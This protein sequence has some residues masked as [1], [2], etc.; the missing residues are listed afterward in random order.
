[1][2]WCYI[3]RI[4]IDDQTHGNVLKY[5]ARGECGNGINQLNPCERQFETTSD[6]IRNMSTNGTTQINIAIL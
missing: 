6:L 1:M 3:F 2:H 4:K 5:T